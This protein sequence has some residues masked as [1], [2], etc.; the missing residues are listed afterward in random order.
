MRMMREGTW[1]SGLWLYSLLVTCVDVRCSSQ[2]LCFRKPRQGNFLGL[3]VFFSLRIIIR[4]TCSLHIQQTDPLYM[5]D[6]GPARS[7]VSLATIL[8][9]KLPFFT[10]IEIVN[11]WHSATAHAQLLILGGLIIEWKY[12]CARTSKQKRGWAFI[13]DG[14]IFARVR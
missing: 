5:S 11:M 9:L 4:T 12:P 14:L 7:I 2:S 1:R 13:Q 8:Y 10:K 3:C 6:L